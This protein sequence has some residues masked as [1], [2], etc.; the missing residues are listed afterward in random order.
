MTQIEVPLFRKLAQCL[1]GVHF[2]VAERASVFFNNRNIAAVFVDDEAHR[3]VVLPLIYGPLMRNSMTHWHA[4][5]RQLAGAV[6]QMF[7][8]TDA[9]LYAEV[10]PSGFQCSLPRR[11][12]QHDVT[13]PHPWLPVLYVCRWPRATFRRQPRCEPHTRV[14]PHL[15]S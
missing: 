3:R 1:G 2:Q 15:L 12:R 8:D 13:N 4:S 7:R 10:S 5:V 11:R 14:A 6:L 9:R